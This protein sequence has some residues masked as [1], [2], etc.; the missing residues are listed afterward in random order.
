M[1]LKT[2]LIKNASNIPGWSTKRRIVVIESDDWGSI[3]MPSMDAYRKLESAGVPFTEDS[4]R[5]NHNDTLATAEDF[6]V[7]FETLQKHKDRTGR[8][9]VFTPVAIVANPDFDRIRKQGFEQYYYEPFTA[10]LER[11]GQNDAFKLWKDGISDRLFVPQFHAREHLNIAVWMRALQAGDEN[12]LNAFDAGIWAFKNVNKYNV[13]FQS[14]F[15]LEL[16]ADLPVQADAIATGL[17]LFEEL[18]GYQATFFVPPNGPINNSLEKTAYDHGIRY[19]S[20]S[21]IQAEALGEGSVKKHFHYLGQKNTLGQRYITRNCFFEPSDTTRDWVASCLQD[22]NIAFRW[23][24][25]AV[26][27]SHRVNFTGGL[28]PANRQKGNEQLA[29]LLREVLKRWPETEFM[30]SAELGDL[31]NGA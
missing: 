13:G 3:R 16:Q 17:Q 2:T 12:T 25:P 7:L 30:T 20:T 27:S 23:N 31:I 8:P 5:Y 28:N 4:R 19:I 26:V 6:N 29:A 14:A 15:D 9:A 10:T 11:Y 22:I 1:G 18:F 24:K 21:K